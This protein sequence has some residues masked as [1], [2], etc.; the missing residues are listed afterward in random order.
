MIE[1][2][3]QKIRVA[4]AAL[5]RLAVIACL[6]AGLLVV[7]F[8]ATRFRPEL[9]LVLVGALLVMLLL[10]GQPESSALAITLTALFVRFTL[11]TGTA[12]RIV[13]SLLLTV[14][15]IVLWVVKM[16][17]VHKRVWLK[18]SRANIPVLCFVATV[19]ISYVWS[20]AF[21]DPLVRAWATWPFVQLGA[22]AVMILLPGAFLLAANTLE[23]LG[24]IKG[25]TVIFLGAG[26]LATLQDYGV[27]GL[28]FLQVAPLFPTWFA[29]LALAQGLFNRRLPTALRVLLV[30]LVGVYGYQQFVVRLA[31]VSAWLP[32]MLGLL[33]VCVLRS[34]RLFVLLVI[35]VATL[36]AVNFG[37][38]RAAYEMEHSVS[39]VTRLAAYA[40]NWRVTG[41]HLLFGVGPAGYAVY[42]M[43]Y[44]PEEGMAT[45]SGYLDVLSQTGI[46]GLIAFL[47]F[48][49]TLALTARDLLV[50]T[51][52]CFDFAHAFAV[53]TVGGLVGTVVAVG[54]GDWV[55]PFVYTQS[56]AGFDYALYTWVLLGAGQSL[57]HI[58][59]QRGR[60]AIA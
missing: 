52:G 22:L 29:C 38:A 35:L 30:S 21:R 47:A 51:K 32:T 17:V 8:L 19:I 25:L 43:S 24:W 20:N 15:C 7:G 16:L 40:Q 46:V 41:K 12:S 28:G 59:A 36:V 4:N 53:A 37:Q 13:T 49:A 11:P 34:R 2:I 5:I 55:L 56:I 42:Y 45:H 10:L 60:E 3:R 33:A 27:L 1:A 6:A 14:G 23:D 44:F 31:W 18:P 54:L 39:G 48:F 58:L 50:R 9:L 57:H 26:V